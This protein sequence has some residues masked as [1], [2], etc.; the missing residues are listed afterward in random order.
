M[1]KEKVLFDWWAG[2]SEF[3][4]LS[5]SPVLWIDAINGAYVSTVDNNGTRARGNII[6]SATAETGQALTNAGT[7]G[8]KGIFNGEGF[9]MEV[10]AQ[11]QTG[12]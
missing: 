10:G 8:S 2:E 9:Y 4:P 11:F 3:D 6:D 12:S 7:L 1:R 5:L